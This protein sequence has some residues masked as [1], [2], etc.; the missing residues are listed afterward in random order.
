[1]NRDLLTLL[2][3]S[4]SLL[5]VLA[6]SPAKAILPPG[7]DGSTKVDVQ[8]VNQLIAQEEA[9]QVTTQAT[10]DRINSLLLTSLAVSA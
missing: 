5:V 2:G 10:G 4:G 6:G 7:V 3:C 8:A 1:M 9:P